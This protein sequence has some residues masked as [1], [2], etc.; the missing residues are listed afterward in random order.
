MNGIV[1]KECALCQFAVCNLVTKDT[2]LS[3]ALFIS[4]VITSCT[5]SMVSFTT[6][7][8][9]KKRYYVTNDTFNPCIMA[10]DEGDAF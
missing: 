4:V 8:T 1:P 10:I 9:Y 2:G 6:P 5:K 3:V 7:W